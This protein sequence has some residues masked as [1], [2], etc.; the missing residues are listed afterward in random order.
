MILFVQLFQ[1]ILLLLLFIIVIMN[2]LC[3]SCMR[4]IILT[5]KN[6]LT[7]N[8][9][10]NR[11][12]LNNNLLTR[13][14]HYYF[15]SNSSTTSSQ[16][17]NTNKSN[18]G[19]KSTDTTP[20]ETTVFNSEDVFLPKITI[21]GTTIDSIRVY[22]PNAISPNINLTS[23]ATQ[24]IP[25]QMSSTTVL[26]TALTDVNKP[27]FLSITEAQ[28]NSIIEYSN[29]ALLLFP[30]ILLPWKPTKWSQVTIESLK[31]IELIGDSKPGRYKVT[32]YNE[33]KRW[34]IGILNEITLTLFIEFINSIPLNNW[35]LRIN[36][37]KSSHANEFVAGHRFVHLADAHLIHL[38]ECSQISASS[39]PICDQS[40]NYIDKTNPTIKWREIGTIKVDKYAQ[41]GMGSVIK[42]NTK[43]LPYSVLAALNLCHSNTIIEEN[44]T[45]HTIGTLRNN[46]LSKQ[47]LIENGVSLPSFYYYCTFILD[48]SMMSNIIVG[49]I[50]TYEIS[51][52]IYDCISS[53]EVLIL[54]WSVYLLLHIVFAC[55]IRIMAK[56]LIIGK[57]QEQSIPLNDFTALTKGRYYNQHVKYWYR[58][59]SP[60]I[61]S[62]LYMNLFHNMMGANVDYSS[63]LIEGMCRDEDNIIIKNNCVID[64]S[65]VFSHSL[66]YFCLVYLPCIINN[67]CIIQSKCHAIGINLARNCCMAYSSRLFIPS[68]KTQENYYYEGVPAKANTAQTSQDYNKLLYSNLL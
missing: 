3:R 13:V 15:S 21:L 52:L 62:S 17:N 59:V 35:W 60:F 19:D 4:S 1:T 61:C 27:G 26:S 54:S 31:L 37:L 30:S 10:S 50:A 6:I 65:Y 5:P 47:I 68:I 14:K 2:R 25:S 41:I 28:P 39:F 22:N 33:W 63:V 57:F 23:S 20:L 34:M 45:L 29:T 40:I 67:N 46:N 53:N 24:P 11:I 55:V 56:H 58:F 42:P 36:G 7:H 43:L 44:T 38:G 64:R 51:K 32:L 49:I 48:L 8:N 16:S 9:T 66:D 18:N 12:I